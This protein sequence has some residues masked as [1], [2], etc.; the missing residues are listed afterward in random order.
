MS[1]ISEYHKMVVQDCEYANIL[2][3][4]RHRFCCGWG[5]Y[6]EET[7]DIE[8]YKL[9]KNPHLLNGLASGNIRICNAEVKNRILKAIRHCDSDYCII[10]H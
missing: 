5:Y 2:V 8:Y 10:S 7:R 6:S 1:L 4:K 9:F 3:T